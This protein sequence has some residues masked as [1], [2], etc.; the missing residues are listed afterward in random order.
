MSYRS[1]TEIQSHSCPHRMFW[2]WVVQI[3]RWQ[4]VCVE[5]CC[6]SSWMSVFAASSQ[7]FSSNLLRQEHSVTQ[8][9]FHGARTPSDRGGLIRHEIFTQTSAHACVPVHTRRHTMS[10]TSMWL[11]AST[12]NSRLAELALLQS[13]PL[14]FTSNQINYTK[15][16][17]I[18]INYNQNDKYIM[19]AI[20]TNNLIT[21]RINYG[22]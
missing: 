18:E 3:V 20:T 7:R 5:C 12:W 8:T 6:K 22:G 13:G 10:H 15:K 2:M 11:H 4:A 16:Q 19:R 17:Y 21:H 14:S 1:I 9:R